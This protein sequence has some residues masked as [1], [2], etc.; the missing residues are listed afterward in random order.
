MA[1]NDSVNVQSTGN[2]PIAANSYMDG[3]TKKFMQALNL[4]DTTGNDA[5][6][7][8]S[9]GVTQPTGGAGILGWL[10]GIFSLLAGVIKVNI[11]NLP[12]IAGPG[13]NAS[14]TGQFV[15]CADAGAVINCAAATTQTLVAGVTG[16]RILACGFHL[17]SNG[18]SGTIQFVYGAGNTPLGGAMAF[19]AETGLAVGS[20]YGLVLPPVPAGNDLKIVTTGTSTAQGSIMYT[21][22]T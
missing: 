2:T 10:S 3:A 14:G 16:K 13:Y 4:Y 1:T 18:T 11:Q 22:A 20:G 12:S 6:G 19:T 9:S 21:Q 17:I 5:V 15:P 8:N 7:T